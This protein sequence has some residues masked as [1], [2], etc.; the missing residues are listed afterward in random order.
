MDWT[1]RSTNSKYS[2]LQ[3]NRKKINF[4]AIDKKM[5]VNLLW[6]VNEWSS[7]QV[8]SLSSSNHNKGENNWWTK[9]YFQCHFGM[10]LKKMMAS[11]YI[12][13]SV[14]F[15]KI[16]YFCDL[17]EKNM[18]WFWHQNCFCYY[19]CRWRAL[20]ECRNIKFPTYKERLYINYVHYDLY[21]K[22]I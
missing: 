22:I 18:E 6:T 17:F 9:L 13:I 15:I 20:V 12:W 8:W 14:W 7:L 16:H 11:R 1:F 21:Y 3:M 5:H 19:W 10:Y 2:D 4:Y